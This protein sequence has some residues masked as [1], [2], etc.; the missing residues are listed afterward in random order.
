MHVTNGTWNESTSGGSRT[1][2]NPGA[3]YAKRSLSL[4]LRGERD[5]SQTTPAIR[6]SAGGGLTSDSV[7]AFGCG[8]RPDPT[9]DAL[10]ETRRET[11]MAYGI[12]HH[13]PGGTREPVQSDAIAQTSG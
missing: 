3:Q 7:G 5:G 11:A 4:H 10:Y 9:L 8:H 2:E 13:F 12:V 1:V 6:Y